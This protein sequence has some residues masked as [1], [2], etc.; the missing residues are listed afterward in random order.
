MRKLTLMGVLGMLLPIFSLQ[1]QTIKGRVMSSTGDVLPNTTLLLKDAATIKLTDDKGFFTLYI[2]QKDTLEVSHVGYRTEILT[3]TTKDTF[4]TI[5][6]SPISDLDEVVVSTGY[7]QI[8]KERATGS[9]VFID[10]ALLNRR[11]STNILDRLDGVTSGLKFF[12]S[13]IN[14]TLN[15]TSPLDRSLGIFI[16]GQ[17]TLS[18][19]SVGTDPL[20]VVD[21]FPYDGDLRNLNPN[22]VQSVTIL[23][24]AAASSIWGARSGNGVIVITTKRGKRN[25]PLSID[26]NANITIQNR[27]DLYYDKNYLASTDYIDIEKTLF[28]QGYFDSD[29]SDASGSLPTT[30]VVNILAASRNGDISANDATVQINE[31]RKNDVRKDLSRYMYQKATSRQYSIGLRGGTDVASYSFSVGLDDNTSNLKRNGFQRLTLNSLNTYNPVKNLEFTAGINYSSNKELQNNQVGYGSISVGGYKYSL[32]YPY[33]QLADASGNPMPTVKDYTDAYVNTAESQGFLDWHYRPL[34]ELKY[35]DRYNKINSLLLKLSAK[36]KV[37]P[38]LNV[39]LQ[40]Q[41]EHQEIMVW[42]N[43][44]IESYYT[45]NLINSFSVRQ[46]DGTFSYPV[47]NGGILDLEHYSWNSNNGRAQIN[48]DKTF[49]GLH[50]INAIAG[51]EIRQSKN[52]G[53][54]RRSYGYDNDYGTSSN[55]LN[56]S[57]YLPLNPI[58]YGQIPSI[59][60]SVIG[61]RNRYLSYFTNLSYSYSGKYILSLSGR[62]DGANIFGVKTNDRITPLWST[63]VGWNLSKE[64]FYHIAW[65]PYAKLRA[66]FGQ[67][68]N[69]YNGSAYVTGSYGQNEL[70]GIPVINDLTAPN[71]ILGWE[72]VQN[73]NIGLD[74]TIQHGIVGGSVEWYEKRGKNLIEP[75]Q[76]APSTG[77]NYI[78]L[79]AASTRTRGMDVVLNTSNINRNL[80][81]NTAFLLSIVK[82]KVTKYDIT[83]TSSSFQRSNSVVGIVGYPLYGLFSYKWAGLDPLNGDPQ[84]YLNGVVSKDYTR[85]INNFNPDS[86]VYNGSGRPT[87]FGSIRNDFNYKGFSLSFLIAYEAGFKFRRPSTSLN[88]AEI[89]LGGA[90]SDYADRWQ[91]VGDESHTSVPSLT[92]PT[93]SDRNTFYQ[94]SSALVEKGDNIRLSDIRLAY[95]FKKSENVKFPF[96]GMQVYGYAQNIGILWRANRYGIDPDVYSAG[97]N[98]HFLPNPFSLSF[99]VKIFFQ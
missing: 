73:L 60:G 65:L 44:T 49:A 17:S 70:N 11:V 66:T 42:N 87:F 94:Y 10:S 25:T 21:N 26:V 14:N 30:P 41:N 5:Q 16:R 23:K 59:D 33:A 93:N 40:Y 85:I 39:E 82:D 67:N 3:V 36:Y 78:S 48:F 88:Y 18:G 76:L 77:F 74:F 54:A 20:V 13:P 89:L 22:D 15:K 46:D 28:N 7:Q 45:R 51:A 86:L 69:V 32:L 9:F 12:S 56:F 52:M 34:D 19:S 4:L 63:G 96:A 84:G 75:Q 6:L 80:K 81:W 95:D 2:A 1:A 83:S 43:Q 68:G 79:N 57:D 62:K 47:P 97:N 55:N 53:F 29:L 58:G 64:S 24:D 8:P 37:L 98:T 71:P 72:K 35:A 92:Y 90:S 27:P 91:K 38:F 61:V 50:Q 99:G 31:L